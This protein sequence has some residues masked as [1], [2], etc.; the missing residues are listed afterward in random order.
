MQEILY[1][2]IPHPSPND[3]RDWLQQ[4]FIPSMGTKQL[5]PDGIRLGWGAEATRPTAEWVVFV[6]G[7]QRTTYLKVFRWAGSAASAEGTLLRQLT[8]DIRQQFPDRYPVP[9]D[10][11][12]SRQSIFEALAEQYPKTVH[13]FKRIPNGEYDLTRVYWW[14]RRWRQG[15]A[16]PEH[17]ASVLTFAPTKPLATL[18][19][20]A[21]DLP[22]YDLIY[23]GGALGAVHAAVMAQLGYRVL[24][25]E[26]LPFGR[27]NREW[28]IS[29][30]E[31]QGLID[32]GLFTAA[33][34][35][36]MIAR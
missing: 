5:T 12:L 24:L 33:E 27:M 7:L 2:E 32:L 20:A 34:F 28:N 15:A 31:F 23:V 16:Q 30:Q 19:P 1:L 9:P 35:E 8:T 6:W 25:L 17:P 13:Y 21:A 29:R 18:A 3:V 26:R 4:A 10:I 14:E 11:D 36:S 22:T